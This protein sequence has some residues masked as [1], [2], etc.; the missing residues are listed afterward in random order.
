VNH[1]TASTRTTGNSMQQ[2]KLKKDVF[3]H[4]MNL[5][6]NENSLNA[7]VEFF[8]NHPQIH[9]SVNI[10]SFSMRF[11]QF[12]FRNGK[13]ELC[14]RMLNGSTSYFLP[15]LKGATL[16]YNVAWDC[17]DET[18][19]PASKQYRKPPMPNGI[20]KTPTTA[21]QSRL[22]INLFPQVFRLQSKCNCLL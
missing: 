17:I 4:E 13:F 20:Y 7:L 22:K 19:S 12:T 2:R 9:G 8:K 21:T 14:R 3:K 1:T 6:S 16:S 5:R 10:N 18:Q 15:D 11:Y